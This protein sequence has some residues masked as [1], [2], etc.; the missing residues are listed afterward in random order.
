MKIARFI[1]LFALLGLA[2]CAQSDDIVV[3][4]TADDDVFGGG[5]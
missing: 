1:L 4:E 3:S 2:A 5:S